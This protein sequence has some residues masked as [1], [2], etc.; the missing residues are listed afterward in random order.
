M[1]LVNTNLIIDFDSTLVRLEGLEELAE[2]S[3]KNNPRRD[4]L[5][6]Q[7][8]AI[9]N[10]GMSGEISFEESLQTRLSLFSPKSEHLAELVDLLKNN[11]SESILRNSEFFQE[12]SENIYVVSGGFKEWILPVIKELGLSESNLLANEFVYNKNSEIIGI[13]REIPL[14]QSGGKPQIVKSLNLHGTT[15]II[16]DGYTD[17]EIKKQ[18]LADIFIMFEEN[19]VRPEVA[20]LADY[21]ADNWE[22]ISESFSQIFSKKV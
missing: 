1:K 2:V 15:I 10:R 13:D 6:N 21:V 5:I 9:T 17:Y 20:K 14:T 16:G 8:C 19:V 11:I 7:I 12:N 3:L 22:Q 4:D 18:G